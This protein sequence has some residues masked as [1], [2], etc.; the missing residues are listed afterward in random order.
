M[1]TMYVG[2]HNM[3]IF[4]DPVCHEISTRWYADPKSNERKFMY[5]IKPF[6]YISKI[7]NVNE[8]DISVE[9]KLS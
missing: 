8:N 4:L 7:T 3:N 1:T 9:I 2:E 5:H 6:C